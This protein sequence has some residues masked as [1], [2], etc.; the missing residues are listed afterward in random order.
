M[1]YERL[2][3]HEKLVSLKYVNKSSDEEAAMPL[4]MS[5]YEVYLL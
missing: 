4:G 3:R 2:I 5:D 1:I